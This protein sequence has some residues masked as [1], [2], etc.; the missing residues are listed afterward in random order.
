MDVFKERQAYWCEMMAEMK[1]YHADVTQDGE[2]WLIRIP[3][4]HRSTQALRYEDVTTM[5][6]E[7]VEIMTGLGS[8]DYDLALWIGLP[9][10]ADH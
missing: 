10:T 9:R 4:I 7:L 1:T 5:T 6:S 3:E 2:F 8:A